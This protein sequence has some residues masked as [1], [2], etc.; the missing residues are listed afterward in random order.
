MLLASV[1]VNGIR[2]AVRRD[3]LTRLAEYGADVVALQEVR[4]QESQLALALEGSAFEDW[5]V[6]HAPSEAKGRAGVAVLSRLPVEE[7]RV[8][9]GETPADSGRWVEADVVAAG[10]RVTVASAYVHT[11]EAGTP[12][13]DEKQ[14][15]LEAAGDR[16]RT[17]SAQGR[18]AVLT[19]DLNVAHTRDDL[20]NW[21]GNLGKAGF[22]PQEQA[23]LSRWSGEYGFV[24]VGRRLH[25]PGPGPY[26]WWSWRGKAFDND[27]GWRIDYHWASAP[28][29]A[30]A[31]R[32]E[33]G[34]APSY[35]ERWSDHAPVVVDYAL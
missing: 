5:T 29:A 4:A 34:R 16:L 13:Q 35:A 9:L 3:G 22:L 31:V 19:G 10:E 1:N 11:G 26:T 6:A 20:K 33:V 30:R 17:W 23:H 32:H 15:F 21:K 12:G 8:G 24:D 7:V 27:A 18:L 2:A 14:R 25:G 28:L